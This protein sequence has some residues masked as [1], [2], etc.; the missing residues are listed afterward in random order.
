MWSLSCQL[1][2]KNVRFVPTLYKMGFCII[3]MGMC[4]ALSDLHM[5][6]KQL[7]VKEGPLMKAGGEKITCD[8]QVIYLL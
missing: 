1:G 2:M 7:Q 6:I 3:Y 8:V 4:S 5:Q